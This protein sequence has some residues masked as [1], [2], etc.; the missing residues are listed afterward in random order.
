MTKTHSHDPVNALSEAEAIGRTAE[1]F[2][3]IREVMQIPLVTSIWRTLDAVEG[4]LESTWAATR[5]IF[6]SGHADALLG[7]LHSSWELPT[8]SPLSA[9]QLETAKI[10]HEDRDPILAIFDAYNRSNTLNLIALTALVR[11]SNRSHF[12]RPELVQSISWPR[13]RPLLEKSDISSKNWA[14]LERTIPL[15]TPHKTT[16]LPTLWRHLIH[17]PGL[18]NLILENYEP[19]HQNGSL[20]HAIG[21]TTDF[22]ESEAPAFSAYRDTSVNIPV[23]AFKMIESYV[24]PQPSVSRMA[25]LGSSASK[26]LLSNG[27]ANAV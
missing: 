5:P 10:P 26:W 21:E 25:T 2:A 1:I 27:W 13:L 17:W 19:L 23:E 4:G 9:K 15:G 16:A 18:I 6:Q 22:V 8:P 24:G 7:K 20:F 14:L 11:R 12:K 3:D